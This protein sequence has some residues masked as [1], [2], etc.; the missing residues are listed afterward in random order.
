MACLGGC[1]EVS[2]LQAATAAAASVADTVLG[3]ALDEGVLVVEPGARPAVRFRH[4][5]IREVVLAGLDQPRLRTLR[6]AMAR[7]LAEVTEMFAVAAEQYLPVVDAVG[8]AAER[9]AV[10][11]LL[12]RAADQA[13]LI[14]DH[15]LV[16]ALL[17][18][19]LQLVDRGEMA[20]LVEVHTGQ[21]AALYSMGHLEEADAE[22]RTIEQLCPAALD[23]AAATAVQMRSLTYRNR[24]A[25]AVDL[26]VGSL[27]ELGIGFPPADRLPGEADRQFGNLYRW[28]DE[29]DA[30]GDLTG[31]ELTDPALLAAAGLLSAAGPAAY[32]AADHAAFA[33]FSLEALRMWLEH[34]PCPALVAV[35]GH[36]AY[37]AVALRGDY[38]AG[39]RA[40]RR[41]L[42]AGEARG[43][44]PAT[45]GARS[46][47]ALY[48]WW[49]EPLEHAIDEAQRAREGLL[50]GGALANVAYGYR[51]TVSYLLDCAS[52]LDDFLAEVEAGLA[53]VRRTGNQHLG[54]SLDSYGWLAG[55]LRGE[56]PAV[57]EA[58]PD[59]YG[60][61]LARVD[62]HLTRALAAAIISDQDGLAR[63][64]AAAMPLLPD[65]AGFYPAAM[66][67]LLRGLALAGQART[68]SGDQRGTLM[69]DL[70]EQIA[71]LAARA[72]DAPENFAYLVRLLEAERAWAIGDSWAAALAFDA[73][74]REAAPRQRPWHRALI[75]ERAARF[76][77]GHGLEHIGYDLLVQARAEYAA[78][79]ATG[80]VAQL[81]WAHPG[82]RS[83]AATTSSLGHDPSA[84]VLLQRSTVTTGTLDLLGILSASQVL[85]SET[86]I[87]RLHARVVEV[88]GALTGATAV[89]LLLWSDDRHDWLLPTAGGAV[90]VGGTGHGHALPMA[91]L[92][93]VQR[94]RETLVVA[95]AT[96]DDRFARD[97]YFAGVEQCSVLAVPI[98]SRGSLQAVL[99]LEN[100]L[101]RGAFTTERLDV[102]KL[103]AGQ[104]AVS[105]DNA[106][107]YA[108]FRRIAD[109]QAA[110]R[111]VATLVARAAPPPQV[112][113][114]VTAEVGQLL[115]TDYTGLFRYDPDGEATAVGAW[116]RSGV[117]APVPVAGRVGI[118]GHNVTTLVF[119]TGRP[120]RIDDYVDA[121]GPAGDVAHGWGIR[122]S[123][124]APINVEGRLWGVMT[125]VLTSADP[126]G[127]DT[128]AR[129]AAFTELVATAIANAESQ[130]QLTASR[131]RIVAAAD[132]TRRR[133]ERD[134]HDGA[135]QRLVSLALQLRFTRALLPPGADGLGARLEELTAEA[136]SALDELRELASGIHPAILARGGLPPA[137][138]T[139]ARRC[140]IPVQLDV[141]VDGPLPEHVEIAA[142]YL[143]AEALTNAAKHAHASIVTVAVQADTAATPDAVLRVTVHDDGVGGADLTR[144]TGLVGLKDRVE[145]LGG[146][147]SLDSRPG[148]GT[149]L[150]AELPLTADRGVT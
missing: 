110:L 64:T 89:E 150:R 92:R 88:L 127:A 97:P 68:G 61:P 138:N 18:G 35:A 87:E 66:T 55:A 25:E 15:V 144:G 62:A 77:L 117:A 34:G 23:R 16:N 109:E 76:F 42:A 7:R 112:F 50:A 9:R 140:P 106:Q 36:A 1:V 65:T 136:S 5:R 56:T 84:H 33:W 47:F 124:G 134:L 44:E 113:T 31:P 91:L 22:Y 80:K 8:D 3:P 6:L 102:V 125:A 137:L 38:A 96:G 75:A 116:T 95:D 94:V 107:L 63:H 49:F 79:G 145:A 4:D 54:Q 131:A 126:L 114:A 101:I 143:I 51:T 135:Q 2:V 120:A 58:V 37:A 108:D 93:Y 52:T 122:A 60:N 85:S 71:W 98:L 70:D 12:R 118:G 32:Y 43:Y 59:R 148:A 78:W 128:E 21:H 115:G 142:Y 72:A 132:Q 86:S 57:E 67:R 29:T 149:R 14:G 48:C 10:V 111:R 28:L 83:G 141:L 45:S 74:L 90:P 13:R 104:L 81:D 39:C 147:I 46:V 30:A 41:V 139:L 103:I 69:A 26:A 11:G 82:L 24:P 17:S 119:E 133:I 130:A 146:R 121:S 27:R 53:F 129:L 73:A 123:V 99:L 100:H 40:L 105:L 20:T 19:A